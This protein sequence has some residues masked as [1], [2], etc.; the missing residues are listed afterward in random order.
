M[1]ACTA[2]GCAACGC[3]AQHVPATCFV[4][5]SLFKITLYGIWSS[6]L[7]GVA[8]PEVSGFS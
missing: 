2:C 1:L 6:G 8:D 7:K 5:R 3:T 4:L